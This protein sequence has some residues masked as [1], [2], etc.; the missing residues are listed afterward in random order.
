MIGFKIF[1]NHKLGCGP[2]RPAIRQL[3]PR[4]A[5]SPRT[6]PHVVSPETEAAIVEV[7][8][9]THAGPLGEA[10]RRKEAALAALFS[11]ISIGDVRALARR[12]TA[13][14]PA[15]ALATRFAGLVPDRRQ[16]LL[17]ILDARSGQR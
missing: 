1:A 12:L 14:Q 8:E 16:R 10:F 15:D 7:L 3:P 9:A 13:P 17:D 4:L 2:A 6:S 11:S 5:V